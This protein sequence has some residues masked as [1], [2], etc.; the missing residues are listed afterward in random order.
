MTVTITSLLQ[1][2][3]DP[4]STG[5]VMDYAVMLSIISRQKSIIAML[6]AQ[7]HLFGDKCVGYDLELSRIV[8]VNAAEQVIWMRKVLEDP[9]DVSFDP[10]PG[11]RVR[12]MILCPSRFS[13]ADCIC[14]AVNPNNGKLLFLTVSCACYSD[15]ATADKH[16]DQIAKVG[17]KSQFQRGKVAKKAKILFKQLLDEHVE[18]IES[19]PVVLEIRKYPRGDVEGS[20]GRD[21]E[22]VWIH[23]H[24]ASNVFFTEGVIVIVS[25]QDYA[26]L[27][28]LQE[29][30]ERAR[31]VA[32]ALEIAELEKLG[33]EVGEES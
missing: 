15:G 5:C 26:Y 32:E 28:Q 20:D 2:T 30:K 3:I 24:N 11:V 16:H 1:Q 23:E 7:N 13:G 4:S 19:L 18:R 6:C 27:K 29:Q 12:N 33:E 8:H 10:M 17:I 9:N 14:V 31:E 22:F 21:G 25:R